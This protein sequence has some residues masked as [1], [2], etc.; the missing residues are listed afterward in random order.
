M[1]TIK[2]DDTNEAAIGSLAAASQDHPEEELLRDEDVDSDRNF[3]ADQEEEEEEEE[4]EETTKCTR[5]CERIGLKCCCRL[6]TKWPRTSALTFGV[7]V[8]LFF[9]IAVSVFFGK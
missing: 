4:E 2:S 6:V 8:P 5:L 7:V 1:S 9:L 3:V